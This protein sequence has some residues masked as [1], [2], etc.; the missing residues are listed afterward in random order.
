[1]KHARNGSAQAPM[2]TDENV[3][4]S[5]GCTRDGLSTEGSNPSP[6]T[7][8]IGETPVALAKRPSDTTAEPVGG[9]DKTAAIHCERDQAFLRG[10]TD[11]PCI[12]TMIDCPHLWVLDGQLVI[13]GMVVTGKECTEL[14]WRR[15]K[16]GEPAS[17]A[18]I[19]REIELVKAC[20]IRSKVQTPSDFEDTKLFIREDIK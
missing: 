5:E 13:R 17:Q 9:L 20:Y 14:P 1:M 11:K 4:N 8:T 12:S 7:T 16:D 2:P 10:D 19:A 18:E 3:V 15:K 6:S